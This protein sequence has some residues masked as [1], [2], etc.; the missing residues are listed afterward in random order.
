MRLSAA[1]AA[2]LA[3][4]PLLAPA[5]AAAQDGRAQ[6]CVQNRSGIV[7]RSRFNYDSA[8][9]QH[10][11]GWVVSALGGENCV[12]LRDVDTLQFEVEAQEIMAWTRMCRRSAPNPR[13]NAELEVSGTVFNA[14]CS[15][16]Q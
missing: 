7:I 1:L 6:F 15:V 2:A 5:P 8:G 16:R 3:L 4:A 11:S 9:Q 12:R 10:R 14:A 13:R